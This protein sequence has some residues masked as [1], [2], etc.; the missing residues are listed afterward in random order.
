VT[1]P[2]TGITLRGS[3]LE[4]RFTV[5]P[6]RNDAPGQAGDSFAGG[7]RTWGNGIR[8]AS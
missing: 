4:R 5:A 7:K 8:R 2:L 6:E 3:E 1:A